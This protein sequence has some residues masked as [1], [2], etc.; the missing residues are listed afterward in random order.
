MMRR[1]VLVGA[2]FVGVVAVA[3]TASGSRSGRADAHCPTVLPATA[4]DP[5]AVLRT[6][7]ADLPRVYAGLEDGG[8]PVPIN[9]STYQ[10]AALVRLLGPPVPAFAAPMRKIALGLC[11]RSV[12]DESWG[13]SVYL[14]R[15][16]LPASHRVL[17]LARTRSG[18]VI[19]HH[20]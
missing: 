20:D 17:F 16:Q 10:I 2:A 14:A 8:Q 5:E 11:P 4:R 3:T 9:P 15:V 18:W 7:R 1:V 19:W 12:V 6:V 13:V